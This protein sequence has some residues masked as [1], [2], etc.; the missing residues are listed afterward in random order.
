MSS[1]LPPLLEGYKKFLIYVRDDIFKL[2]PQNKMQDF[3]FY[4]DLMTTAEP[5][6]TMV[7]YIIDSQIRPAY[8]FDK[9]ESFIND[10]EKKFEM[11]LKHDTREKLKLFLEYFVLISQ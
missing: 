7:N 2:V 1:K 3:I 5:S 10:W 6:Q 4:F 11:K 8:K 9:G